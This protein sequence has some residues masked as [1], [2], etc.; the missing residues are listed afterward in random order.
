MIVSLLAASSLAAAA[1]VRTGPDPSLLENAAQAIDA[2]RL[3]EAKLLIARAALEG[4]SGAPIDRLVARLAL[5]SHRYEEA[6]GGYQRLAA[7]P[8]KQVSD[9]ENGAV[10]ALELRRPAEA[11]PLVDCAVAAP[12]PSWRAWNAQGVLADFNQDWAKA[13]EAYSRAHQLLP[14]EARIINNEGDRK[15]VV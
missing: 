8:Q 9:C 1:P 2:G 12:N 10:A 13:D 15:S 4:S 3:Q 7:S 11:K 5:V 14:R 6:L